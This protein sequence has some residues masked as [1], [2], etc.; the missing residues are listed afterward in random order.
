MGYAAGILLE[1]EKLRDQAGRFPLFFLFFFFKLV[2]AAFPLS[3]YQATS[4]NTAGSSPGPRK[5]VATCLSLPS[6]SHRKSETCPRT[7][8]VFILFYRILLEAQAGLQF[9]IRLPQPPEH[10][11]PQACTARKGSRLLISPPEPCFPGQD[12]WGGD[13]A[14]TFLFPSLP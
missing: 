11:E 1:G 3:T 12:G 10:R 7:N 4:R 13:A 14:S 9:L 8:L 6:F 5:W 2:F